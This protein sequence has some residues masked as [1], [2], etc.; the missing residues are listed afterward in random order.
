MLLPSQSMSKVTELSSL[1]HYNLYIGCVLLAAVHS[2]TSE[3]S[4]YLGGTKL[5]NW[6]PIKDQNPDSINSDQTSTHLRKDEG[7][8][9]YL[10]I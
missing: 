6:K 4:A 2:A 7:K 5:W 8:Q 9:M 10:Q 1:L 3:D